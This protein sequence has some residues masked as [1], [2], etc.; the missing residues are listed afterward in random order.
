MNETIMLRISKEFKEKLQKEAKE[1]S[2]T[3]SAY[4]K[5]ILNERS[6]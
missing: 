5:S 3:L 6:K 2:L 4:I 1:K